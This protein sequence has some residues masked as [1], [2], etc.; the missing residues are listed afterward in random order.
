MGIYVRPKI[1]I[2]DLAEAS[3]TSLAGW[4]GAEEMMPVEAGPQW[5][6]EWEWGEEEVW[7][8]AVCRRLVLRQ[9]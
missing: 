9:L 4:A 6:W 3:I 8:E 2:C 7:L 5:E 1:A